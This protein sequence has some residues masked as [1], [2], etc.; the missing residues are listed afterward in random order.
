[1]ERGHTGLG[2]IPSWALVR[3]FFGVHRSLTVALLGSTLLN[4]ALTPTLALATGELAAAVEQRRSALPALIA[5]GVVFALQRLL[6]PVQHVVLATLGR[7]VD[8]SLTARVMAA[9]ASPPGLAHVEDPRVLDSMAKAQGALDGSTPGGAAGGFA[10]VWSQRLQGALSLAL[11]LS[12]HWWAALGLLAA[13]AVAYAVSRWHWHQV[14]LVIYG[15]TEKLRRAYYLR[16]LALTA[17]V[18]K[19]T[20]I[21]GLASWLVDQY[22]AGWLGV[23]RD[24]WQKRSEGWLAALAIYLLVG[25]AELAVLALVAREA[26]AGD[27][28]LGTAVT[29]TGATLAAAIVGLYEYGHWQLGHA[30]DS[31]GE[32]EGLERAAR[33]SGGGVAGGVA[34]AEGLPRRSIRFEGVG[35]RYPGREAAV[36]GAL[37]L[38]I[39]AG[40][41]L[42]IVGDNGAG[43]TTL[44]KLLA[45]LY[46]PQSGRILVDG[47]DLREIAPQAWH[48]R[49][50]AIFQD[51]VQ[52]E[53]SAHDN[54]AFGALHR[55]QDRGAVMAAAGL[56]GAAP[57]IERL[58]GGW[59][60]PL[61]RQL[62][63]GAE[64]S[65]GEWQRLA[66][67]RALFAVNAGA[68]VLVLD[69]PTAAL[70]VRGE[71][72]VYERFLELT[73]GV[74]TIVISHRF[75]TVRRADRIIVLEG[76]RV[77][78]D[79]THDGLMR[80]GGRYA[81]LYTLQAS[82]FEQETEGGGDA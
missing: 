15:R 81:T 57:V 14:T 5:V 61:S 19:E 43:K 64:L 70:D 77:I 9:V 60:T 7:R 62:K 34:A 27:I 54:V 74:T 68:G 33:G 55:R 18:A 36:F 39:E 38:E 29:I 80:A 78:E 10:A 58:P 17:T 32:V 26:V 63:G 79:G 23:M 65:G 11:V 30:V 71:A 3:L 22:R 73:R 4:G 47:Q 6:W 42:A 82:R 50:A 69:E 21:F 76:G 56:A 40:R 53:L 52:F 41:S 72:E 59:D 24:I 67:A 44:V 37:D 49:V 31:L 66:L 25:V 1:M 51:F 12:W 46:D 2:G 28:S 20:R 13:Y 48:R 35:F 16:S 8:E 45:R 75:S